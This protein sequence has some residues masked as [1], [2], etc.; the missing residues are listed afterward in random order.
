MRRRALPARLRG[1]IEAASSWGRQPTTYAP[2]LRGTGA[3]P[4]LGIDLPA[5]LR[6]IATVAFRI[7]HADLRLGAV[8]GARLDGG[9]GALDPF[10]H[11]FGIADQEAEMRDAEARLVSDLVAVEGLDRHI[12]VPVAHMLV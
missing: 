4:F 6:E 7:A 12:A 1:K 8:R 9:A 11:D 10:R 2:A 5:A 3:H